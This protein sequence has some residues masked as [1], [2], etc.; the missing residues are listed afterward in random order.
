MEN[1]KVA[2][3][4]IDDDKSAIKNLIEELAT[5]DEIQVVKTCS[6][7][8]K[9]CK[10]I[11]EIKPNL[12][13]LDVEMPGKTGFE[14]LREL[15]NEKSFDPTVVFYTSYDKYVLQALRES[16]FDF[17]LKPVQYS[18]LSNLINRFKKER[19]VQEVGFR[20]KLNTIFPK[21]DSRVFIP[22]S[23]GLR[24]LFKDEIVFFAFED[25]KLDKSGWAA[26]LNS[27]ATVKIR[28]KA[29]AK[30]IYDTLKDPNFF[31]ANPST[32]LNLNYLNA[33]EFKTRRCVLIPP[34]DQYEII[35]SRSAFAELKDNFDMF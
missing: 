1:K 4:I 8:Q 9:A 31:K 22:T 6:D 2:T 10:T 32:I 35:L 23:T 28:N 24:L 26:L 11:L 34:F 29:N 25:P 7:P 3:V 13:F 30:S 17:L 12:I 20:E 18:E 16:A 21:G 27:L 15:K 14:V 19:Y 33:I 5:F